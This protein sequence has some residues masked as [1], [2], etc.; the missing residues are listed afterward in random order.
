M[1]DPANLDASRGRRPARVRSVKTRAIEFGVDEIDV[2]LLAGLVDPAQCRMIGDILLALS[3]GLCDGDRN[4]AELL[5]RIEATIADEGIVALAAPGWGDRA[6][7]RRF[8]IGGALN[9][10]R[11]LRLEPPAREGRCAAVHEERSFS[12]RLA[13]G[14]LTRL[15]PGINVRHEL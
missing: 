6:V 2:S 1:P 9:R 8:E 13:K 10:L 14:A 15:R 3:R 12:G 5:D 7:A 11:S 4:L